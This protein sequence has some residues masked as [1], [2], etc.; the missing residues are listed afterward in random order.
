MA[1][2]IGNVLRFIYISYIKY[3]WLVLPFEF[4]Q[5]NFIQREGITN[6]RIYQY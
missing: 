3:P 4:L 6:L 1:G 2:L 5:G